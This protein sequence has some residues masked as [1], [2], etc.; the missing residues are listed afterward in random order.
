MELFAYIG[1]EEFPDRP[2]R[3]G[4][5]AGLTPAG[6]IPLVVMDFDRHKLERAEIVAQLQAQAE[7]YGKTIR[8]ARF[9]YVE[10]VL[11]IPRPK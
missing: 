5:K 8:L 1:E 9:T 4:L 6:L 3:V 2:Q 10:D 7:R 11:A